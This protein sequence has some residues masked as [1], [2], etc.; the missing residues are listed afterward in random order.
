MGVLDL[1]LSCFAQPQ[2]ITLIE[3]E[4]QKCMNLAKISALSEQ[5]WRGQILVN[6]M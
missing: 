3:E 2:F 4:A 6:H 5:L 1:P